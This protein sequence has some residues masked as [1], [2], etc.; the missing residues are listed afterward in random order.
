[1]TEKLL[2]MKRQALLE[3]RL[4]RRSAGRS[5]PEP[6]PPAPRDGAIPMSYQQEALWIADQLATEVSPYNLL[7]ALRLRGPLDPGALHTALTGLVGRHE[8]LRTRF[9]E[10]AGVPAQVIDPPPE[11]IPLPVVDVLG[12]S[13][14]AR[15]GQALSLA[16]EAANQPFDLRNGPLFRCS[17]LRL[18]KP[19]DHVLLLGV[20]HILIDGWSFV[21]LTNELAALYDAARGGT[22]A[23]LPAPVQPADYAV[24]QHRRLTPEEVER[25]L[26]YWREQLRDLPTVA[27]P[28]DRPRPA[29]RSGHG[30]IEQRRFHP[31]LGRAL[32]E[33]G[34]TEQVSY[35]ATVLAGFLVVIDRYAGGSDLPV[36]TVL[37]GR[38][39][40]QLE[41]MVG[42]LA[43][44]VVLRT[45]TAGNPPFREL[46]ARC[47]ETVLDAI[48]HQHVPFAMVVAELAPVRDPSR[49]PLFQIGLVVQP[50]TTG[51]VT[52]PFGE[53][54][55]EHLAGTGSGDRSRFDILLSVSA[56][57]DGSVTVAVEYATELFDPARIARMIDDLRRVLSQ[58]LSDPSMPIQSVQL[59]SGA[60]REVVL[61]AGDGSAVAPR[62]GTVP[63]LF[64]A[65]VRRS[66]TVPAVVAGELTLSYADLD[67]WSD[68]L[69]HQLRHHG[70]GPE[71][72][73]G[74]LTERS[75]E[76]VAAALAIL[77]AGGVYLPL[78]LT[79]PPDRMRAVLREAGAGLLVADRAWQQRA[80]ELS[81]D[82]M[83]VD[84]R[85][86]DH[87][88]AGRADPAPL[89]PGQLAYVIYTSGSTGTPKGVAVTHQ[90]V[91]DLVRDRRW[92]GGA[93]ERVLL[94]SPVAFDAS[95]YELW[96]PLLSG[97]QVVVA[98]PGE[99]DVPALA[100]LLADGRVTAVWLTSGLFQIVA[101][102][103]PGCLASTREVW[104][105][106]DVLPP[107][108][109]ERVRVRCPGT[110]VVN[111]YGPTE[112]TTFATSYQSGPADSGR[113]VLPIGAPLDNMRV[114]VL[115]ARLN[116][117]PPGVTGELY[118]AGAG[119]A[120]GYLDRPGL[121]AE[122]FVACPFGPPGA[123]MYRTGD[124]VLWNDQRQLEYLGRSDS[125]V[126]VRG[127]RVE[128]REA[129]D[130]LVRHPAV[131]QA[132]VVA[133][134][135]RSGTTRL[136]S[137][138]VADPGADPGQI[139]RWAATVL[140]EYM[141]PATVMV[142]DRLPL[143]ANGKVD[144]RA[145]PEPEPAGEAGG[146]AP[147]THQE[148]L[149][150]DLFAEV[151]G[152]ERVGV[153]DDF[154]ALGGHS[155]LAIRLI[156]RAR[157]ALGMEVTVPQLFE[158]PTPAGLAARW[159]DRV[160]PPL[161]PMPRPPRLP[162]SFAQ[163]RL[164]FLHQ[165][166][167]PSPTYNV[168]V[169]VRLRGELDVP[170]LGRALAQ[171]VARHECLR[172]VYRAADG[173][174]YQCVLAPDQAVPPLPVRAVTEEQV[175]ALVS[176]AA[177]S[178]FD[179]A[180][181]ITLR[182][183][184][185]SLARTE[186]VLLVVVHHIAGD[187]LSMGPLLRDLF[188]A[189]RAECIGGEPDWPRLPVQYADYTLWQR[190]LLRDGPDGLASRQLAYWRETLDGSPEELSLP[191]DRPRP[192]VAS[193]RGDAV[194]FEV[195]A[196]LHRRLAQVAA[197]HHVTMFMV[198]HAALAAL[199]TRL[200]GGTDVPIGAPAAG[201]LDEAL[202]DLVGFFVNTLVLR[203]DVAGNPTFAELLD[204]VR[205]T[206][207]AAFA[208]QDLPFERLV[209]EIN[210]PRS[211]ARHP[212]FQVMLA[213]NNYLMP[214]TDL[215][216][217]E[218]TGEPVELNVSKFDLNLGLFDVRD[219]AGAGSGIRGRL[220]YSTDL[221][222]RA[223]ADGI[224]TRYLRILEA[225]AAD[226]AKRIGD[227]ELMSDAERHQLLVAYNDTGVTHP[228]RASVLEL[229]DRQV[230]RLSD[231]VAVRF[232]AQEL[233]YAQLNEFA[234]RLADQLIR[235][236]V[237]PGD[238]VGV[239]MGRSALRVAATVAVVKVGAAYA[240]TPADQPAMRTR[241]ALQDA[242][243][244]FLLVDQE[245]CASEIAK[246]EQAHGTRVLSLAPQAIDGGSTN[247]AVAV[248]PESLVCLMFTSGSTGRPKGVAVTHRNVV[249]LIRD[250][251][252]QRERQARVLVHSEYGFDVS[253]YEMWLPLLTGQQLVVA[254]GSSADLRELARVIV[255]QEVTD[256]Y[257]TIG[258]FHI[259]AE[260]HPAVLARLDEVWT[261]GDVAS[262]TA[263][264]RVLDHCPRTTVV[265]SYGPTETTVWCSYQAFLP[266]VGRVADLTL[267]IPTANTRL[268]VL[269]D[270]LRP[271]PP[272]CSGELYV[273]GAHV[274]RGYVGRPGLTA[275][276]FV[277]DP[278]GP[279]GERM[280]RTGD[281]VRWTGRGDLKFI[282]RVDNQV[283]VRGFRIELSEVEAALAGRPEV[284]RCAVVVREDRPGDKRVVGYVVPAG[285]ATDAVD[286]DALRKQVAARVPDYMV[287]SSV[288]VLDELPLTHNGKLDRRALPTPAYVAG[289]RGPRT[290]QE[291][292]LCDLFAEVLG[293][294]TVGVE[295]SFF[296]LGGHSLLGIRL[297]NRIR[298]VL[299][300]DMSIRALISTPTVSGMLGGDARSARGS[301][302][303][304]L[305]L[306]GDGDR[307]PLFCVHPGVG[308]SWC[309][310]SLARHLPPGQPIFG[311]QSP[312]ILAPASAP[313]SVEEL[314]AGYLARVR[315]R[316]PRGP[317]YLLG[318][319]FGGLVAH[320]MANQLRRA[321]EQV[322][323]L[324]LLDSYPA[325]PT[326]ASS[327]E[328]ESS[329]VLTQ[330]LG[331]ATTAA[332]AAV[333]LTGRDDAA[334]LAEVVRRDNPVLAALDPE[335]VAALARVTADH[336]RMMPMFRPERFDG[337][338]LFFRADRGRTAD[339][340]A[341]EVWRQFTG[342]RLEIHGVDCAHLEMATPAALAAVATTLAPRLP[343]GAVGGDPPTPRLYGAV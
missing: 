38:D 58:L 281:L 20:H 264:Q 200:G 326:P 255:Q 183:W 187:G 29:L 330:L 86:R 196:S 55:V 27:F 215:P 202:D 63:E 232:G 316:Q 11:T 250:P 181:D 109:V 282:G 246:T 256:A 56:E 140:P 17:L 105:G 23:D 136:V 76:T 135:D 91:V 10:R 30:A 172:T 333:E 113:W 186:H 324:A 44:A 343:A 168:P 294:P 169:A 95:T 177:S 96:V 260:E 90:N 261:G 310:A 18:A 130:A 133:R 307:P 80:T 33:F 285:A 66:P 89:A 238:V 116:L 52:I 5:Q 184:L 258:L 28:T 284:A 74:L 118:I 124:Q 68:R 122:R 34:R 150:C 320:A 151:L 299:G 175:P 178:L 106:G 137:Y 341:P 98:P 128:L 72:R 161:V 112:T 295:D 188:A 211:T 19:D 230:A 331:D 54:E 36:G 94:H 8:G 308:M 70:V 123:R 64:A 51:R 267:G 117:V 279:P 254:P 158:R 65:Q 210:P 314:A 244:R 141:V 266:G 47:Q 125:Q 39:H 212:L 334:A 62:P 71:Q 127:F 85:G 233:T 138:V 197:D 1:M 243:A 303:V 207:L 171:C 248:D 92:R 302:G 153:H 277:A 162:L 251:W 306:R 278:F 26:S 53:V 203:T 9:A 339:S 42:L 114:Y 319:S 332:A 293:V 60:E 223:T 225:I 7:F 108:A 274:T 286:A 180:T 287:P 157:T 173:E 3:R 229:F 325:A 25:Q 111:G 142:I 337:D 145:L 146:A 189:Y 167:G 336:M 222:D 315:A 268:Y 103:D 270:Q 335:D 265:H 101:D 43:N 280:Y 129:E 155:L 242:S 75:A 31:D 236:G 198:A 102:L 290:P 156:S 6:I 252:W 276:R 22:G 224:V 227:T 57:V 139:R 273:A 88:G 154:F 237:R 69:A 159:A 61:R 50:P 317:Y 309:Y 269:D 304:L 271:V 328:I 131:R 15:L 2:E 322:A 126:K 179:L 152:L 216:G 83:V 45:S 201:R 311:L 174:P 253:I 144:R 104:A 213:F 35:L 206:D 300:L 329:A 132:I 115:D 195:P 342:G 240:P 185:F 194:H 209:E 193:N 164:W 297:L 226:P 67:G 204:R 13:D 148:A 81:A 205:R 37:A 107:V 160:R 239:L 234:N 298:S 182:S 78:H 257:F 262:P 321:G 218:L 14:R 99:L 323:L 249:E 46:V 214:V 313:S 235:A 49:N 149:A 40:S 77:K 318:W 16:R 121:T 221:F 110:V 59:V 119:L 147:G 143:T 312:A 259:M 305:P 247:P 289:G 291:M 245:T 217:V 340:P 288:V 163:R 231:R 199:L 228:D 21:T 220:Q 338:M 241:A 87:I 82:V 166:E 301:L 97:G 327:R 292:V 41:S 165:F 283:K 275:V 263:F 100:R 208:N 219:E 73:V 32:T 134:R 296:D 84:A 79:D 176:K 93:H 170:A 24:W 12:E 120:R 191:T 272:G 48:E 190:E 4:R 192:A